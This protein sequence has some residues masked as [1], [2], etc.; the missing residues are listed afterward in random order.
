MWLSRLLGFSAANWWRGRRR[1]LAVSFDDE[2][3]EELAEIRGW[4]FDADAATRRAVHLGSLADQRPGDVAQRQQHERHHVG[5]QACDVTFAAVDRKLSRDG[6]DAHAD[7]LPRE[8]DGRRR[9]DYVQVFYDRF[10]CEP[11]TINALSILW[12]WTT[13]MVG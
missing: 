7:T 5:A 3:L 12:R 10:Q 11:E 2:V 4:K 1:L 6:V 13:H 9:A 8:N